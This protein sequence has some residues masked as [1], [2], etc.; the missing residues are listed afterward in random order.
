MELSKG[1]LFQKSEGLAYKAGMLVREGM[2]PENM[3][4]ILFLRVICGNKDLFPLPSVGT[5]VVWYNE[6]YKNR[7]FMLSTGPTSIC[8]SISFPASFENV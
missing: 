7:F 5:L 4:G 2:E 8:E 6:S 1:F 3:P